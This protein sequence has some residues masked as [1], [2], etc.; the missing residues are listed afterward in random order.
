MRP[1]A[2]VQNGTQI[3]L[4]PGVNCMHTVKVFAVS[5]SGAA[6]RSWLALIPVCLGCIDC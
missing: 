6:A 3:C 4:H 2:S 1:L 5:K